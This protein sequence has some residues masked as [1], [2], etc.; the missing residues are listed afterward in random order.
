MA[1]AI[2]TG[3]QIKKLAPEEVLTLCALLLT[4]MPRFAEHFFVG[5]GPS[6]TGNGDCEDEHPSD[7]KCQRH[8]SQFDA[9]K[10]LSVA[11]HG[12]AIV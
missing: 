5:H 3:E 4:K 9:S 10:R 7:L 8:R 2:L 11:M 12:L 1:E 6:Y